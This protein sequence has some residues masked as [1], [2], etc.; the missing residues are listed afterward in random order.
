M[1]KSEI[2]LGITMEKESE[3]KL[4]STVGKLAFQ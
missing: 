1:E 4:V 2:M 3:V